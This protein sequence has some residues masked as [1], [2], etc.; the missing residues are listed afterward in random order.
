MVRKRMFSSSITC[1]N[2]EPWRNKRERNSCWLVRVCRTNTPDDRCTNR[3]VLETRATL[4]EAT[5]DSHADRCFCR[6][7]GRISPACRP[8]SP[9]RLRSRPWSSSL[10]VPR[11][12]TDRRIFYKPFFF[13]LIL[14]LTIFFFKLIII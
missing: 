3:M 2:S 8:M 12:P 9:A 13:F 1:W 6:C 10:R 14:N 4:V 7:S 5:L 11:I